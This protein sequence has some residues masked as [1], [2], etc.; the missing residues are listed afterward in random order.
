MECP[1]LYKVKKKVGKKIHQ[2]GICPSRSNHQ[3]SQK[4]ASQAFFGKIIYQQTHCITTETK[5]G[6][7]DVG[8]KSPKLS[9]IRNQPPTH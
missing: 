5:E 2:G 4:E 9:P 1:C 3:H 8:G 7:G 6:G